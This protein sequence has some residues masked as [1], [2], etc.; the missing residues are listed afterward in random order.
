VLEPEA[1]LRAVASRLRAAA[2]AA[3]A[4]PDKLEAAAPVPAPAIKRQ[5]ARER[6]TRLLSM[7]PYLV[8]NQGVTVQELGQEFGITATQVRSDLE[9]LMMC[10]L[11]G[12]MHGD[13]MDVTFENDLVF[14]ADADTLASPLR[15]SQEEACALLVGLEA[16]TAIPGTREAKS[17]RAAIDSV[18]QVAGP[19][20][21]VAD[22]VA[23]QLVSAEQL[24]LL[25]ALQEK[26]QDS[27]AAEI[28]YLVRTRDEI[29]ERIIEPHRIFSIDSTW[30][31]RAW[32]RSKNDM[33]SFRLDGIQ[34]LAN[35]GAQQ[36]PVKDDAP[37]GGYTPGSAD[38]EI[39][40][41]ADALTGARLAPSYQAQV[42]QLPGGE[43][44]LTFLV[45][46]TGTIPPLM[47][48]LGGNAHVQGPEE[49][50]AL[51]AGWL[52]QAAD[53]YPAPRGLT[54]DDGGHEVPSQAG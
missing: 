14:I 50:R 42:R 47:A 6:L 27:Q 31:V 13:L 37:L 12:G 26:I 52:R 36:V 21:W 3:A 51:T 17:L 4:S 33:R 45:G 20:A 48:R 39:T 53:L 11:P 34:S 15:L 1:L 19:D 5:D 2:D 16:L 54:A 29:T 43:V 49:V 10:G 30:Y 9:K 24:G 22:A 38:S 7:V 35:A 23:L 25:A 44:A 41:I 32:C 18:Q 8:A 40:V 28:R 46:D